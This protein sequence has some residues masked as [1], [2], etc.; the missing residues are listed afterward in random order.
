MKKK[1]KHRGRGW[2]SQQI[3]E[4]L[5]EG[6]MIADK[7]YKRLEPKTSKGALYNSLTLLWRKGKI[8]RSEKPIT[9]MIETRRGRLGVVRNPAHCYVYGLEEGVFFKGGTP[10]KLVKWKEEYDRDRRRGGIL[11]GK[12][13]RAAVEELLKQKMKEFIEKQSEQGAYYTTEIAQMLGI[14]NNY[15]TTA[16]RQLE[17]KGKVLFFGYRYPDGSV[18]PFKRG[19]LVAY[20]L[21]D[22][23]RN[24]ALDFAIFAI[25]R[26]LLEADGFL[27]IVNRIYNLIYTNSKNGKLTF[28]EELQEQIKESIDVIRLAIKRARQIYKGIRRIS[29]S[30][31]TAYYI[32]NVLENVDSAVK[33]AERWFSKMKSEQVIYS[34]NWEAA[35]EWFILKK[36]PQLKPREQ[37]HR[38]KRMDPRRYTSYDIIRRARQEFDRVF[39]E[40]RF[41]GSLIHVLECKST[42]VTKKDLDT[43]IEKLKNSVDFGADTPS[44]RVIKA[45]VVPIFAAQFFNPR[46][47]ITIGN[48]VI[49]L[50]TYANRLNIRL[51]TA[52]ELNQILREHGVDKYVTVQKI[53]KYAANE[54]EVRQVLDKIWA[55]PQNARK[56]LRELVER[57]NKE[58]V[59]SNEKGK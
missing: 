7:I 26:R 31:Y 13:V 15:V 38:R 50:P 53:C 12:S 23:E 56:I 2:L 42:M 5:E 27:N 57:R 52:A 11:N 32:E 20:I 45:N 43:F 44:G 21:E 4:I 1:Y 40:E 19:F 54:K 14:G 48:E 18:T 41:T 47:T 30:S 10:V 46:E 22:L 39:D 49:N 55:N 24:K 34:H 9:I 59:G 3:L 8:T 51:I 6:P 16:L 29:V 35:V 33:E 17:A 58:S 37:R 25:N 28:L 36:Q